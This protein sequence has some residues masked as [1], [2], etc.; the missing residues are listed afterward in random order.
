MHSKRVGIYTP[1]FRAAI[2]VVALFALCLQS[3]DRYEFAAAVAADTNEAE[4]DVQVYL[5][6]FGYHPLSALIHVTTTNDE[7]NDDGDCS[8]REAIR[9]ANTNRRVDNCAVGSVRDT[10]V[11]PGGVYRLTLDGFD[12]DDVVDG[13][14]SGDLDIG[15]R[16][17]ISG[18]L[19]GSTILDGDQ[20]DRVLHILRDAVVTIA[21][22]TIRN[23]LAPDGDCYECSMGGGIANEG[24]TFV[25]HSTIQG[26]RAGGEWGA[27]VTY[28]VHGGGI[29]NSGV[30]IV[31]NSTISGNNGGNGSGYI[32][33]GG[34]PSYGVGGWGGG[35]YNTG[36]LTLN[37]VTITDNHPGQGYCETPTL[38]FIGTVGGILNY[39][40]TVH[41]KNTII[42][43]N[44]NLECWGDLSSQGNN[45]IEDLTDCTVNSGV[46]VQEAALGLLNDNGGSTLTHALLA[47][48][49]AIDAGS[50]TDTEGK[51]VTV[52]Q[53]GEPRP[54]GAGCDIGAYEAPPGP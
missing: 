21:Y 47:G 3:T 38:C 49:P 6:V 25:T 13:N 52:D 18:S 34:V 35:I 36:S 37:N 11:L 30:M 45:L 32:T 54:Q 7:L 4:Q 53:R 33:H 5:P 2:L 23:G 9:T 43:D 24:Y 27:G 48:S 29:Y 28:G 31:A 51:P 8:L 50:C 1:P 16:V 41:V 22:A 17:T 46:V 10:I 40:G 26:N 44:E 19:D 14:F 12:Q 15:S 20:I 42:S 39:E